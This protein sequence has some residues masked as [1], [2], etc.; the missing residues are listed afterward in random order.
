VNT[1]TPDSSFRRTILAASI[2][3]GLTLGALRAADAPAPVPTVVVPEAPPAPPPNTAIVPVPQSTAD[4]I[5]ARQVAAFT[6]MHEGFVQQAKQGGIDVLFVGDSIMQGWPST[7][8]RVWDQYYAAAPFKVVEFGIGYDRTQHVL[9]RLQ[10]GEGQGFSPKVVELLIGTNNLGPNTPDQTI[11]GIK[12]VVAELRKDFPT[13]RILLLGILPRGPADDPKRRDVAYV[14]A[15]VSKL[16]DLDHVFYFDLGPKLLDADG[17]FPPGEMKD[18]PPLHPDAA[19]YEVW[20]Q[21]TKEPL[22]NLLKLAEAEGK[23]LKN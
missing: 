18:N 1:F 17:N 20:A 2:L 12:A 23:G 5:P 19:G 6:R 4:R 3:G 8:K 7:G 10:N 16:N 22:A 15:A 14:N 9:W 13:A 11:E 21:A